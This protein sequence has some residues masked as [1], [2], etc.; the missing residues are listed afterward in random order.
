MDFVNFILHEKIRICKPGG[1]VS[2]KT[3]KIGHQGGGDKRVGGQGGY[4]PPIG[5]YDTDNNM[6]NIYFFKL[7]PFYE[8]KHC[9]RIRLNFKEIYL[10]NQTHQIGLKLNFQ[11]LY[12]NEKI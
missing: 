6:C 4:Q 9:A 12:Q 5:H 3:G 10:S 11:E 1:G 8:K 7:P 2:L